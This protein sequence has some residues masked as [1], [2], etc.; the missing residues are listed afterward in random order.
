MQDFYDVVIVGGGSAGCVLANR[1]SADPARRVLLVEAGQDMP[2]GKEPAAILDSYP[3]GLFHGDT[4]IWPGLKAR[5]TTG[6]DGKPTQRA[7]EQGRI[8]G[9]G[10]SINV[11]AANRGLPRDYDE[12]A[13]LGA[14]GWDWASVLPY[15]R[16][17]ERDLDCGGPLH[18]K[19]GPLPIRRIPAHAFPPFGKAVREAFSA[20]GLP[21]REDQNGDFEDGLFPPAFSNENDRR[22]STAQ[23]YLDAATRARPNLAIWAD[24]TV[25]G[26]TLQGREITG[27]TLRRG[28]A[29]QA[30]RAGRVVLTAGALQSP[31]LLLRAGIGPGDAL[32][33]L[34]IRVV[35]DL[36]GVGR[37]LRD[38]PALTLAQFLPRAL[39]LPMSYRRASFLAMRYS[40]GLPGGC[41]SDMYVTASARAGWHA[42]GARLALYFMWCNRPRSQGAVRL[43]SPDADTHPDVD[44][45]L[46]SDDSDLA[47]MMQCVRR[48]AQLA[49][50]PALNPNPD[51]LFPAA[52]TPRIKRLSAY[53]PG[54]ARLNRI[55]GAMLDVPAP[56]RRMILRHGMTGGVSLADILAD[57]TQLEAF[58]RRSVFGVWHAS[59]TCRMGA[60]DD[61]MAVV[62][63]GGKVIGMR[64]LH[65]ADASVM[66]RLPTANTNIPVI[67]IAEKISDAL[68]AEH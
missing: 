9:G 64:N 48:V 58:V 2:P 56:L 26:L 62:D 61:P 55:L 4:Y 31:A 47:R 49:V 28:G 6:P 16:K 22:V 42:L 5:I 35:L 1:L 46:L 30:V 20:S 24:T 8:L 25:Q 50:A 21:L 17:L 53:S 27:L 36:P 57:D 40:S 7:Y 52:F 29:S 13:E 54:N 68:R 63:A 66:P 39:R 14:T 59:G 33:K 11:Q 51:D 19:D 15:F 10:S 45:G 12:W 3:M 44:L 41:A 67:M 23:A 43:V 65:V 34:G 60:L 18:G 38:H 32:A 37:N